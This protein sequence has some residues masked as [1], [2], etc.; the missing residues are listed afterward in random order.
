MPN[1]G[2]FAL[3]HVSNKLQS[4]NLFDSIASHNNEALSAFLNKSVM[5]CISSLVVVL[6]NGGVAQ[7]LFLMSLGFF[8]L[9]CLFISAFSNNK[10]S[11]LTAVFKALLLFEGT[12]HFCAT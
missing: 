12:L 4:S 1:L 10:S 5:D 7:Q 2:L 6:A 11:N 8:R 3:E 9:H